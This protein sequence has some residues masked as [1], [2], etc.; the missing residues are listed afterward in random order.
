MIPATTFATY[1]YLVH[2]FFPVKESQPRYILLAVLL[3]GVIMIELSFHKIALS[4]K[5]PGLPGC[6]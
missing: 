4:V 5:V 2:K 6:P 3:L 1:L